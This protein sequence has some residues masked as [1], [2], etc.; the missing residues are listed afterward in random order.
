MSASVLNTVLCEG[1]ISGKRLTLKGVG[2]RWRKPPTSI[3]IWIELRNPSEQ[4]F[5]VS[6]ELWRGGKFVDDSPIE[7][8]LEGK[9]YWQSW[10]KW[11]HQVKLQPKTYQ[12]L[13]MVNGSPARTMV[14]DFGAPDA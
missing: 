7:L 2:S 10:F 8:V 5:T 6:V 3:A 9:S 14:A 12:F 11:D 4:P 1:V 13:V